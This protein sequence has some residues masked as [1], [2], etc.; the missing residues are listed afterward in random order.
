MRAAMTKD[1]TKYSKLLSLV[2]RHDPGSIGL[3]L[4]AEGWVDVSALI[5]AFPLPL[6]R[7]L[8][9]QL[10]TS[11]DKQRFALSKDGTRIRA[12]QGHSVTV[13]LNLTVCFPPDQLFHGT[14]TRFLDS[15]RRDGLIRRSRHHVHLS[16]DIET[17]RRVGQRHG[18]PVVLRVDARAMAEVGRLFW[19]SENGVWLT[20]AVAPQFLFELPS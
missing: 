11:S 12:N 10:V 20:D 15:I 18:T 4:D 17:A 3:T 19:Q 9:G 5:T 7:D 1:L 8:L 2:L 13:D 14:A 6:D 16:A